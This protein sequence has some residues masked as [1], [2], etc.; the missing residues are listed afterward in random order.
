[1]TQPSAYRRPAALFR[2]L[3][4]LPLAWLLAALAVLAV[5]SALWA[6]GEEVPQKVKYVRAPAAPRGQPGDTAEEQWAFVDQKNA[7]C[8]SCH[9]ASDHKTMHASPAVVLSCVDCHGGNNQVVAD[10]SW[11]RGSMEYVGAMK[12]AHVLP[13]FPVA[14]GWPSSANPKRS[15]ALLAKESPEFIRFV[16]PSDYRVARD[17]C[18]ACHMNII[19]AS[20]RSLMSTGAMLWGGAAYNNGIVPFKNYMFGESFTRQGEPALLKSASKEIG[21]DGKPMWGTVTPHEKA[22]GALPALY[23][24][25]RWHTI[26]PADVFRVFEDGGR[27]INPQFPEIGLPNSTG[28]IQRLDEPGRP[29]L[30]QSNRGPATGLR[31]AIP[32]LNI[33]P[34]HLRQRSRAAPQPELW[35]VRARRADDHRRSHDQ[36]AARRPAPRRQVRQL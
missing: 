26:P 1:M 19:E 5:P 3:R 29:D 28:L 8:V 24:L 36:L 4:A 17:S 2:R 14:W 33:V 22:R 30:K 12:D 11:N 32:V 25:P 16:N 9:T 20:E 10:R 27:A 35:Q 6:S 31:V 23:P 21:P 18:G 15:Y 7:G 13:R 34:R